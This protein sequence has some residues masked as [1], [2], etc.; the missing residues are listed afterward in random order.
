MR[1]EW[2]IFRQPPVYKKKRNAKPYKNTSRLSTEQKEKKKK[3]PKTQ[4]VF[5]DQNLDSLRL[6]ILHC[7]FKHTDQTCV[8][9]LIKQTK[10]KTSAI[11]KTFATV[12]ISVRSLQ[13]AI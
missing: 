10:H 1:L 5:P 7:T 11:V 12:E 8:F 4:T 9:Q 3:N 2:F 6:A 13:R